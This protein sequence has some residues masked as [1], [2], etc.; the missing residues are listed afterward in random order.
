MG[1]LINFCALTCLVITMCYITKMET[2]I[3]KI[4]VGIFTMMFI[5]I[6]SLVDLIDTIR[7][8]Y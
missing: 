5:G 7:K 1:I 4:L 6:I 8:K 2:N 3:E